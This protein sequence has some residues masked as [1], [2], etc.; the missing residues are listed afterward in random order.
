MQ[1]CAFSCVIWGGGITVII[2]NSS[3]PIAF[4]CIRAAALIRGSAY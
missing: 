4:I 1:D 3:G 2:R